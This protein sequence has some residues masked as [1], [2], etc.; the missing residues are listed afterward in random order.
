LRAIAA[1]S[2]FILMSFPFDQV[3]RRF[4]VM[5]AAKSGYPS[6]WRAELTTNVSF[7]L[8]ESSHGSGMVLADGGAWSD[9][10]MGDLALAFAEPEYSSRCIL[11]HGILVV[12]P[13]CRAFSLHLAIGSLLTD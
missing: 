6:I 11:I 8:F 3:A 5:F 2:E 9:S 7:Y 4:V 1:V 12:R 13:F 10:A